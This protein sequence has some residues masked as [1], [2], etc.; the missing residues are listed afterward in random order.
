MVVEHMFDYHEAVPL[1][2][3]PLWED[4]PLVGE[5]RALSDYGEVF[6]KPWVVD[7]ILDLVGY[8]SD[9]DLG[10][11]VL[12]EPACGTGAFL[13]PVV[14][15]LVA[16]CERGGRDVAS[17]DGAI[18][19][20]DVLETNAGP[21]REAV[22]D[23]LT[24]AGLSRDEAARLAR[25]WVTTSDFLLED[26]EP[27]SADVVVGNPPY[28][29]LES[30]P[31]KRMDAY[32]RRC[33][34]MR[35]RSD[36][37][38]GFLERGLSLLKP[39]GVLG[40]ICADRWMRNQYGADLRELVSEKYAVE[41]LITMHD[42]DAFHDDVSS[43]PAVVVLRNEVQGRPVV[44]ETN[45]QFGECDATKF[46][47]WARNPRS[48][49]MRTVNFEAT[50]LKGWSRGRDLWPTGSPAT[51]ATLA[52]LE[53]RFPP[54]EDDHTGTRVR[55][56]VA[57]GC[58]DVF[59]TTDPNLVEDD[60]LLPLLHGSDTTT[61]AATWTG[62]YLVNPWKEDGLVDLDHYPRLK[63]YVETHAGRLRARHVAKQ[64][65]KQWYRTIDRVH[66]DLVTR[67]KIVMPDLK[68]AGHPVL[69][70]GRYYP[71]HNLYFI[72]SDG[73][74]LE[75]LGGILLSDVANLFVGAYS[76]RMR[77]G[78]YRFQSQYV[79]RIRV[80]DRDA[81]SRQ[82]RR[83]LAK[84]FAARDSEAATGLALRL[85]GI[86]GPLHMP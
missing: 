8:T 29:R 1:M 26:H 61:G 62:R 37:Y 4:M 18:R 65:P 50:R 15:R 5:P 48:R 2:Q 38:V 33:P 21:A 25:A 13:L 52:E 41:T 79:R 27:A 17:L 57:T 63:S 83:A 68:S 9:R 11:L 80:P 56:G 7:L 75:E 84:A 19:A 66:L 39:E 34:T 86:R 69:D 78:C 32:R 81:V 47:T 55:I 42:V 44:V 24:D 82:D 60:R 20:F 54:L 45:A 10:S 71:H 35:G 3:T 16:S 51:L 74:D 30:V 58:D 49:R 36:I 73:W 70:E 40:Y 85:Y 77:G 22:A 31:R 59:I 67:P 46:V 14:D 64:R 6:T 53:A 72:V 43:Y 12:V 28:I 76:V 23:R